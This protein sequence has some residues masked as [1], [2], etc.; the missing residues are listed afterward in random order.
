MAIYVWLSLESQLFPKGIQCILFPRVV[1]CLSFISLLSLHEPPKNDLYYSHGVFDVYYSQGWPSWMGT[2]LAAVSFI[3]SIGVHRFIQQCQWI[4]M[5]SSWMPTEFLLIYNSCNWIS[6]D[7][8]W[9]SVSVQ[10]ISTTF[11][12]IPMDSWLN[13][14][15]FQLFSNIVGWF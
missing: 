2:T 3:Y 6:I 5:D 1:F 11:Q 7:S 9:V 10:T 13:P 8:V 4:S 12:W 14:I 15:G